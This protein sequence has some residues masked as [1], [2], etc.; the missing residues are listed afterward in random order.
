MPARRPSRLLSP[1]R[2][3]PGASSENE[4]ALAQ[5]RSNDGKKVGNAAGLASLSH[6]GFPGRAFAGGMKSCRSSHVRNVPFSDGRPE[7]AACRGGPQGDVALLALLRACRERPRDRRTSKQY[8][9]R[10]ESGL[11]PFPETT[12]PQHCRLLHLSNRNSFVP[13]KP[14][15]SWHKP[16]HS[17]SRC[18]RSTSAGISG[19][20]TLA[21][22]MPRTLAEQSLTLLRHGGEHGIDQPAETRG[23][24]QADLTIL[25]QMN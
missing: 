16:A 15:W 12:A 23:A 6:G 11:G 25:L 1:S 2:R 9:T 4:Q 3:R 22:A 21:S 7:M 5:R 19:P 13:P 14:S 17:Q 20:S 8:S 18:R 10:L 24:P